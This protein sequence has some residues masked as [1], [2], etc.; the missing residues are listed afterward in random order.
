MRGKQ[1]TRGKSHQPAVHKPDCSP[2]LIRTY[3]K[4]QLGTK[5]RKRYLNFRDRDE[6]DY[7]ELR[8]AEEKA[9][10]VK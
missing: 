3:V 1:L 9:L 6:I 10:K 5:H 2:G 7:K 8:N 4:R